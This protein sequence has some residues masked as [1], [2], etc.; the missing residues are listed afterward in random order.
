MITTPKSNNPKIDTLFHKAKYIR[1]HDEATKVKVDWDEWNELVASFEKEG[2]LIQEIKGHKTVR[3]LWAKNKSYKFD[4]N[5]KDPSLY[6]CKIVDGKPQ[7]YIFYTYL[8]A[9]KANRPEKAGSAGFNAVNE[10]FI[11][12][13]GITL[14][15]AFGEVENRNGITEFDKCVNSVKYAIYLKEM[16]KGY[17]LSRL[18]KADISSAWPYA[19]CDD[20][21]DLARAKH[22]NGRV[23]PSEEYPIAYYI[24]SGHIA[25]YGKYDT[26]TWKKNQWYGAIEAQSKQNFKPRA[27]HTKWETFADISDDEEIT[28][29]VPHSKYSLRQVIEDM[30]ATKEDKTDIFRSRWYKA[31]LNSFIGFMRS[32]QYNKQHYMGHISALAY[33]RATFRMISMAD[34]LVK[35]GNLP[36]YFAI[37]SIIWMGKQSALTSKDKSLGAFVEEAADANGIIVTHGQYCLEANGRILLERHQGITTNDYEKQGIGSLEEYISF[38]NKS[39]EEVRAYDKNTH[40]FVMIRRPKI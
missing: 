19:I 17:K 16:A 15:D 33:A 7:Y 40:K 9:E 4:D 1:W 6:A 35:E 8:D 26:H 38:M 32:N 31:M 34:T 25:E 23:A 22:I 5:T 10:K 28:V 39:E 30:Y 27:N 24:K 18:Y 37:D 21:P 36:I 12:L 14:R 2:Y 3:S 11:D 13:Y 29:L 20:L